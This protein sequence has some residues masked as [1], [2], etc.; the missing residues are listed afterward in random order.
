MS[1]QNQLAELVGIQASYTDNSG[2]TVHT[3]EKSRDALLRA[4]GYKPEDDAQTQQDIVRLRDSHWLELISPVVIIKAEDEHYSLELTAEQAFENTRLYWKITTENGEEI[5]QT[6]RLSEL[7]VT[8]EQTLSNDEGDKHYRCY[9]LNLPKLEMGYHHISVELGEQHHQSTIIV[10]P[11]TCYSPKDAANFKMWGLAAQLYSLK[12]DDGWGIGDYGDLQNIVAK[13]GQSGAS[14]VGLNPLHPLY[15]GNPAHR[16]PYSPT[17]RCFLNTL[18]IDVTQVENYSECRPVKKLVES[19]EFQQKLDALNAAE[20]INYAESANCK[21]QVLELLYTHFHRNHVNKDTELAQ[22]FAAFKD[23]MGQELY[24]FATFDAL[25]EHFRKKDFHAFSWND[26]PERYQDPNSEY[27]QKFQARHARRIDY[28]MYLQWLADRQLSTA[29]NAAKNHDMAV[30]LYLDLAV[31]CDGGGAEVWADKQAYVAGVSVGAPPDM[32][33]PMGQDWGLTPINPVALREKAYMPLIQSLRSNMRHAGAL[34]VDHV[35]G[36]QRQYWVG[37]G[38]SA[39]EGAYVTFPIEDILRIIALESRRAKCVVVGED[40]G[41][42]PDGFGEIMNRFGLLS[43]KVL[44]FERWESGLFQRPEIYPEQAM[45]TVSTHDMPTL[46]GWWQGRD[47]DWREQL[48]LY[49]QQEMAEQER[50]NRVESRKMLIDALVDAQVLNPDNKPNGEA[51]L[52]LT[53]AVQAYLARSPGSIQ[54]IPLEDAMGIVEQVN[55]PGT[56]DEHPNWLQRL[57]YT[58]DECWQLPQF[59]SLVDIMKKERPTS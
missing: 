12:K 57:P 3:S 33:N 47:L 20:H 41:T 23:E 43:Y 1:L 50:H 31:G 30:G 40:L 28:F 21:Y 46:P 26:W 35:F 15:P 58:V 16:S 25:Y 54:M 42:T 4:M 52:D 17:S 29:A 5:K 51:N 19:E 2:S 9:Q 48:N 10:A 32:L 11:Q 7:Q 27:V 6:S 18:Y 56:I 53:L 36:L 44:Y 13:A 14:V 24:T 38:L 34:R 59:G 55:I 49:P 8:T 22:Q 37:P 45:V 39:T